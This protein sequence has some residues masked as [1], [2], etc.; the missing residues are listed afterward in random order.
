MSWY[1]YECRYTAQRQDC[2]ETCFQHGGRC[3]YFESAGQVCI[4]IV[5]SRFTETLY[6]ILKFK[7]LLPDAFSAEI[8]RAKDSHHF[9]STSTIECVS[10]DPTIRV[11][12]IYSGGGCL[13]FFFFIIIIRVLPIL[14]V[15]L[16]NIFLLIKKMYSHVF[17]IVNI[18]FKRPLKFVYCLYKYNS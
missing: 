9:P 8:L 11:Q 1:K 5:F 13:S 6:C 12:I 3:H 17:T 7:L 16:V 10:A 14:G 4:I 15:Y 18:L 2:I